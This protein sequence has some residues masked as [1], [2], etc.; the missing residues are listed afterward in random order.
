MVPDRVQDV[1]ASRIDRLEEDLKRTLQL[2]SVIG[3]E[4]TQ[5]LVDRIAD[6]DRSASEVLQELQAKELIYETALHPELAYMF[7]HALTHE[8]AYGSLLA[9]S[10]RKLHQQVGT[11]IEELYADRLTDHFAVL[12]HHFSQGEDWTKAADYFSKASDH[13]AAASAIHEAITLGERAID[14]W[15]RT[16]QDMAVSKQAILHEKL[17]SFFVLIS[18]FISAHRE[19]EQAAELART[20]DDPLREGTA[21][22]GMA[23]A[24]Q[25]AHEFDRSLSEAKRAMEIAKEVGATEIL[26]SA[27]CTTGHVLQVTGQLADSQS[28]LEKSYEL[29][30]SSGA[31]F[32]QAM[33]A[34]L[35]S[36]Y[37][38]WQG[39]YHEATSKSQESVDIARSLNLPFPLLFGLFCRGVSLTGKG[40]YDTALKLHLEGLT[41]SEKLGDEFQR[42]R[43]LNAIGWLYEECGNIE[44]AI[45]YN[46][47]AAQEARLRGDPET[48]ANSE[49]NFAD[50]LRAKGDR[51]AARELLNDVH[52]LAGNPSTSEWMK[53]RY[54]Q[55]LFA[56][57][58]ETWLALDNLGKAQE[59]CDQCLDLASRM[60]SGKYLARGWRLRG[61]VAM[62]RLRWEEAEE[63][64]TT[65]LAFADRIGNPTQLWRTH[66]ALGCLYRDT[67]RRDLSG[68]SA[69]S[70]RA[71]IEKMARHAVTQDLS[72]SVE[73]SPIFRS[74]YGEFNVD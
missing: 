41:L 45:E 63:A 51:N 65:A 4:F 60:E 18:D 70:V 53:W 8:V 74:A 32:Y 43:F 1:L 54:S 33:S 26:A 14:A 36:L 40:D 6:I 27:H 22:A 7:K 17:A 12:G 59:F 52:V 69:R 31:K 16:D 19:S 30:R 42:I 49:L 73:Q 46:E 24:S 47:L 11:A 10:R 21:L 9:Q 38:N 2:A 25:F 64:L 50:A 5:R 62:A 15:G 23:F 13:A 66:A 29:S 72:G 68:A 39:N 61:E 35:L 55:H 67:D 20:L 71:V 44:R 34:S 3:R 57:L 48:I 56:S 28:N 37:N 58:G